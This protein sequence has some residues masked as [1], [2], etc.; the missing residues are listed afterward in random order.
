M[1]ASF[2]AVMNGAINLRRAGLEPSDDGTNPR[3]EARNYFHFFSIFS[4]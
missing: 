3:F 2:D 4:Q 1:A